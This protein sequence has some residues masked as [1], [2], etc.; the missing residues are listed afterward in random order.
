[1]NRGNC[2]E[3]I[4]RVAES[5]DMF[6]ET[7]FDA[8]RRFD[9]LLHAYV[10]LS[11]HFHLAL[12]TP[13]ANL[14]R[15]MQWLSSTFGKR[16][17]RL[18]RQRGHIF[19]G[20]YKSLHIEDGGYLLQVVNY[21]HLNPVRARIVDLDNLRH[22]ALSSFPKFF[23]KKRPTC[24]ANESWL[25][26]AGNLRPTASGMRRYHEYLGLCHESDPAKQKK[27]HRRLCC[28]WHVGTEDGKKAILQDIAEGTVGFDRQV[29]LARFGS[30]GGQVLLLRGL[31]CLNKTQEDLV[32]NRKGAPWKIVLPVGLSLN[33]ASVTH[34]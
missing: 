28:G 15:G 2:Q 13:E 18:V 30:E 7:L 6:E 10:G 3:D 11:N 12:E 16:F 9:W 14:V 34:G 20:R 26:L 21:I 23:Q 29:D 25:S 22:Y 8:C 32:E 4:F 27:I 31:S 24:L 5:G 19:Q 17:N 33:A 1:M